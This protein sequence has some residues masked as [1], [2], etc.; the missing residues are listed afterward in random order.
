V[1]GRR[2]FHCFCSQA[3][4][5][6]AVRR[7]GVAQIVPVV[8]EEACKEPAEWCGAVGFRL[9]EKLYVNGCDGNVPSDECV[10]DVAKRIKDSKAKHEAGMAPYSLKYA[11]S[12]VLSR[13]LSMP[14]RRSSLAQP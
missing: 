7:R 13:R 14:H 9:G 12:S 1:T 3:E 11:A 8:M 10:A 2:S 6:Y 4:F 5:D